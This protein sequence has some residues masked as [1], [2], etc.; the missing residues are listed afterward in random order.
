M[1]LHLFYAAVDLRSYPFKGLN[2]LINPV[3]SLRND[4]S[5]KT[6]KRLIEII[7]PQNIMLDS[8]GNSIFNEEK[9]GREVLS[10][11]A[12]PIRV[13]GKLN[14]TPDHVLRAAKDFKP[15]IIITLDSPLQPMK[16]SEDK[17]KE[18]KRKLKRNIAWAKV[19]V[20]S[21]KRYCPD[22]HVL[23]PIQA[24]TIAQFEEFMENLS[25]LRF[26]GVSIPA[27]NINPTLLVYILGRLHQLKVPWV[28]ILGTTCFSYLA[29]A[30]YFSR[31]GYFEILSMDSSSWKTGANAGQQ[32][33][34]PSHLTGY[35]LDDKSIIPEGLKNNCKCPF[36]KDLPFEDI[37]LDTFSNRS[38]FLCCH[39]S[40][41]TEDVAK[42]VYRNAKSLH[43]LEH[44]IMHRRSP[45]DHKS[46][47]V[48]D[49]LYCFE[50]RNRKFP[51]N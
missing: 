21:K 18:F 33:F 39:N 20:K 48:I 50:N 43:N 35:R 22:A 44:Y 37:V 30:A 12:Q 34:N 16:T 40:W 8:G 42:E 9:R 13:Q 47:K 15:N 49:A 11:P 27:R 24:K 2:V 26:A 4:Y 7:R 45:N 32:W 17:G 19:I 25:G 38:L 1:N 6:T 31:Q 51:A 3:D 5:R 14:L 10:D 36:C 23:I 28:H 46:E 29:V 41:V